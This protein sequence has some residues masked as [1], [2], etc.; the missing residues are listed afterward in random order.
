MLGRIGHSSLVHTLTECISASSAHSDHLCE[1]PS[2]LPVHTRVLARHL[3]LSLPSSCPV[4]NIKEGSTKGVNLASPLWIVMGPMSHGD[5]SLTPMNWAGASEE[6]S[7]LV[8]WGRAPSVRYGAGSTIKVELKHT[9]KAVETCPFL[10][11]YLVWPSKHSA[12]DYSIQNYTY[13][14]II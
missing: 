6:W 2:L 5:R 1:G 4:S 8:G 13:T 7:G 12:K 14:L 11:P 10:V 3:S 9:V